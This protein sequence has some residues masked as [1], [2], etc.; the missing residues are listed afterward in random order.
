MLTVLVMVGSSSSN[1]I[2]RSGVGIGSTLQDADDEA[3]IIF[4]IYPSVAGCKFF[5]CMIILKIR[6]QVFFA[7]VHYRY[8]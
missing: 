5:K 2:L 1:H 3:K 8:I 7:Q 6:K 4:Q